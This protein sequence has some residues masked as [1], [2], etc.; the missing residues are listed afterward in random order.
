MANL[1]VSAGKLTKLEK[2][3]RAH[4][5]LNRGQRR[6]IPNENNKRWWIFGENLHSA[7]ETMLANFCWNGW[8][9][10]WWTNLTLSIERNTQLTTTAQL[11][12]I[13]TIG[14][15]KWLPSAIKTIEHKHYNL[16]LL[17]YNEIEPTN[18]IATA[19]SKL[20]R[21]WCLGQVGAMQCPFLC[22]YWANSSIDLLCTIPMHYDCSLLSS[23]A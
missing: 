14:Y 12:L 15:C 17:H 21:S 19:A 13:K 4:A 9:F 23:D 16:L 11:K 8:W 3:N 18:S 22:A 2:Q 7:G 10:G 1:C 5:R 20:A 6:I